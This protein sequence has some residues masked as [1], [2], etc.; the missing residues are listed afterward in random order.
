MVHATPTYSETV[1]L[2]IAII[3]GF[4]FFMQPGNKSSTFTLRQK[5]FVPQAF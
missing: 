5:G 2:R 1:T 4:T 3:H